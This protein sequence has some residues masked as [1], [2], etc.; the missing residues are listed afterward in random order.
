MHD[1]REKF[2]AKEIERPEVCS[3]AQTAD[4]AETRKKKSGKLKIC[5]Q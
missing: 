3:R 4:R 2:S 5:Q 1:E